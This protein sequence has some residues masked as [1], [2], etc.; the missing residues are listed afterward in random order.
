MR[1]LP[2]RRFTSG[3]WTGCAHVMKERGARRAAEREVERLKAEV[4]AL[5][6]ERST[7]EQARRVIEGVRA[8][9]SE[10]GLR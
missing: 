8:P 4:E 10:R 7:P 1:F 6:S 2:R 5:K 9:R 3:R